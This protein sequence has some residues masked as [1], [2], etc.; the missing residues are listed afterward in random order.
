MRNRSV[1]VKSGAP[2]AR[3]GAQP[4]VIM[5]V[6]ADRHVILHQNDPVK[7]AA[8]HIARALEREDTLAHDHQGLIA[9]LAAMS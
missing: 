9:R 1:S 3:N 6:E 5:V 8:P 2:L 7:D 4:F